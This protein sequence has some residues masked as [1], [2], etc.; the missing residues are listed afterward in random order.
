MYKSGNEFIALIY[1]T[2]GEYQ[3]KYY[4]DDNWQCAPNLPTRTDETGNTNNVV[5]IRED[6]LE[7]DSAVGL[8]DEKAP[9][10]P[11]T[12]YTQNSIAAF[13]SDPPTLP[14][15]LE[16]RA[17]KPLPDDIC[18]QIARPDGARRARGPF[19]SHVYIDHLY[20]SK[21][22][23]DDD[24]ML[25]SQTSRVGGILVN[26]VFVTTRTRSTIADGNG[27]GFAHPS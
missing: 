9:R 15:H 25:L 2:V 21:R 4:V 3:F 17:L 20:R 11:I 16:M 1:V 5:T 26:T 18:P 24:V 14:P 19:T 12:S 6:E 7:F 13:S 23:R 27:N 8:H 10:S 22:E